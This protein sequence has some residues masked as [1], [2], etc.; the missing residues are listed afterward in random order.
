MQRSWR[1]EKV[2][3][4]GFGRWGGGKE[5]YEGPE[6]RGPLLEPEK[7]CRRSSTHSGNELKTPAI[8]INNRKL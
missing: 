5:D 7:V 1:E 8:L 3:G 6:T 2:R 4:G